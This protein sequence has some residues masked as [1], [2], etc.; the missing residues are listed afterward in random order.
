MPKQTAIWRRSFSLKRKH[1]LL[2]PLVPGHLLSG[3]RV[4]NGGL[5][6]WCWSN[7]IIISTLGTRVTLKKRTIKPHQTGTQL[8]VTLFWWCKHRRSPQ[9]TGRGFWICNIRSSIA[10]LKRAGGILVPHV[11]SQQH[12]GPQTWNYAGTSFS[13]KQTQSLHI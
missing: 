10:S 13:D 2:F 12:S 4:H 6:R 8:A 3:W 9:A 5:A 7:V 11:Q 1:P